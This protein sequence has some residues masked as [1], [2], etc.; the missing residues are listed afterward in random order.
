MTAYDAEAWS[1]FAL[2]T[3]LSSAALVGLLLV[4]LTLSLHRILRDPRMTGSAALAVAVPAVVLVGSLVL[5]VPGQ[6]QVACGLEL[7][8]LGLVL[9]IGVV[10]WLLGQSGPEGARAPLVLAFLTALAPAAMIVVGGVS[11][12]ADA[13]GGLY[14]VAGGFVLGLVGALGQSWSLLVEANRG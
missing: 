7:A 10:V 6:S 1:R 8:V 2:A 12:E 3:A 5:L 14:W 13:G 4:A 9:G 11:V